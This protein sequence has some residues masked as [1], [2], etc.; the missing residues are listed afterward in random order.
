MELLLSLYQDNSSVFPTKEKLAYTIIK[1]IL[2]CIQLYGLFYL[3]K[4]T[5]RYNKLFA[6][7]K[8]ILI[9]LS[10]F[11]LSIAQIA[12]NLYD[13]NLILIFFSELAYEAG[14]E[15]ASKYYLYTM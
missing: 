12:L 6:K 9:M 2:S 15:W 13:I 8:D 14:V 11:F 10:F 4:L 7:E 1:T 5:F 3:G